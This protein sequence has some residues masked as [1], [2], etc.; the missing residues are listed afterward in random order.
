MGLFD[1][2]LGAVN[3]STQVGGLNDL[4]NVVS[5]STQGGGL[6]DL[7]NIANTVKQ[8]GNNV[9]ADSST[10]QSI[11]SVVG[12][13]VQSSLQVKQATNGTESV[14]DFVNQFAGTSPNSE[15]VNTLFSPDI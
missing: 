13:E 1:Q 12:K 6:D 3:S 2:I 9:G 4:L 8:L 11:L 5:N 7:L 14:Q 10:I 15:A